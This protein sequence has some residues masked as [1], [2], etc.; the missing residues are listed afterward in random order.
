MSTNGSDL[1]FAPDEPRVKYS[2][3]NLELLGVN[4]LNPSGLLLE[5]QECGQKWSPNMEEGGWLPRLWW[6]CP[7]G[8]NADADFT[9]L[10]LEDK[11]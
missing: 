3:E 7:N 4:E 2:E 5:C 6:Q 9:D 8:C 1:V 10:E 11:Y